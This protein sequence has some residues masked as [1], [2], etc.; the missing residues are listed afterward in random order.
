M[1]RMTGLLGFAAEQATQQAADKVDPPA[2]I[3]VVTGLVLV[4]LILIILYLVLLLMG[5]IFASIDKNRQEKEQTKQTMGAPAQAVPATS[6]TPMVQ[7]VTAPLAPEYVTTSSPAVAS[8]PQVGAGI[9]PEVVA[10]IA[11][12]VASIEDGRYTLRSV[13][14]VPKGRGAWGLAGVISYT[15]PF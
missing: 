15:E 7:E 2:A 11:A 10:A 9:P 8:P 12:A 14:T 13:Q 4:F 1:V 3:V 5:R 6:A